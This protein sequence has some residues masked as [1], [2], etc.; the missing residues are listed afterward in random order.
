MPARYSV[1]L[2]TSALFAGVWSSSGGGRQVLRLGEVGAVN[3]AVSRQVLK[4]L[5]RALRK[6]APKALGWLSLLLDRSGVQIVADPTTEA[7]QRWSELVGHP[8]AAAIV[9]A[10]C[11]AQAHYLVTLDRQHFLDN[12]ALHKAAPFRLG[13]PGDFLGWFRARL[14][15]GAVDPHH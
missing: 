11:S 10:A 8:A 7:I 12:A 13:T 4:E 1:F 3:L 5:E 9:A 2:D 6:K 14:I 15:A